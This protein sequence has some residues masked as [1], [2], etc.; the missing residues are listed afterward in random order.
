M[1]GKE[2]NISPIK[3]RIL[4]FAG[5]LGIS[6]RDFY[7]KIGVS[8]GTLESKTGITEDVVTKFFATYPEVSV[9]W[10][11]TGRGEM[12]K[13]SPSCKEKKQEN[14]DLVE[15]IPEVSYNSA[16]G[17]PYYDVD[18]LGGFNEIVNSQVSIPTNNIVIQGFEKA[19]FWCNVTGHSMEPKINHG[20]I[21]AL[22]KCTLED[23]QYGEIYAVVLDTLRTIK[24]LRRSTDPKELRF[25]PI[26]TTDYDEQEYPIERIM[27]VYEVIGSI[28]KFF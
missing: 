4:F 14:S 28:S 1:Q 8:R 12:L 11:M 19:D 3:Q 24:I 23:I 25:V 13:N 20:D 7:A 16:I 15:K 6:K 17:K 5:T 22:H 21:I 2:Q 26:N 10:L 9:E 18:F 27:N